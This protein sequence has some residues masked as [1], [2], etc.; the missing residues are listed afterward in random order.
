M[1]RDAYPRAPRRRDRLNEDVEDRRRRRS[2]PPEEEMERMHIS[3]QR[4]PPI[5]REYMRDSFAMPAAPVPPREPGP[6]MMMRKSRE[7]VDAYLPGPDRED[8]YARP[9]RRRAHRPSPREVEDDV[10]FEEREVRGGGGR[11]VPPPRVPMPRDIDEEE[12]IVEEREKRGGGGRRPRFDEDEIST[13]RRE[14]AFHRG[15]DS[16][17]EMR[18][19]ERRGTRLEEEEMGSRSSKRGHRPRRRDLERDELLVDDPEPETR[20]VAASSLTDQRVM[21]W[22]DQPSPG[23]I[24]ED[25][26]RERRSRRSPT[27]G[28]PPSM[29]RS[30][31]PGAFPLDPD[32][33]VDDEVSARSRL[34]SAPI[35]G[36]IDDEEIAI[37]REERSLRRGSS[38]RDEPVTRK[39]KRNSPQERLRTPE[40]V[41][42]PVHE[43]ARNIDEGEE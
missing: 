29:V 38:E 6:S 42:P 31:L 33:V 25:T 26:R 43:E 10:V 40:I 9:R 39:S 20:S 14:R 32:E 2:M 27:D 16:E 24:E 35:P 30:A 12:L 13:R 5:P 4:P 3:S 8:P 41:M 7:E 15:Y 22:K 28:K 36:V 11:R 21:Q 19:H 34:R 23:E 1:D 37:R 17:R 18:P